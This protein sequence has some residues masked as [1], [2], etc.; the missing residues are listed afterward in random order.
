LA[1]AGAR[2]GF[3]LTGSHCTLDAIFPVIKTLVEAGAE[4]TAVASDAVTSTDTRFGHASGW[5]SRLEEVTGRKPLTTIAEV[6]PIGPGRLF[7]LVI[8]APCTGNTLAKLAAGI[9]DGPVLMA[10]KAHLRNGRPV[11]L[12]IASNDGLGLNAKN[13]G[14]LL[15][16]RNIYFVPF[17][18]DA[19][20]EKPTSLT[21]RLD[22]LLPAAEAALAGRQ[23]QPLLA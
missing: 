22:R 20:E 10:A 15:A 7:D 11:L 4:V 2:I 21:A 18:Q 16:A 23:Y 9:T 3:A 12:A 17:G 8:I 14:L 1:L 5:L 19:P 13:I 6:E